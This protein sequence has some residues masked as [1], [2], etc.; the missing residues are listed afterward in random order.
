MICTK[1]LSVKQNTQLY[2]IEVTTLQALGLLTSSPLFVAPNHAAFSMLLILPVRPVHYRF[3]CTLYKMLTFNE[4]LAANFLKLVKND[5]PP[6]STKACVAG[7]VNFS[8]NCFPL[9]R[10]PLTHSRHFR[11][12]PHISVTAVEIPDSFRFSKKVVTPH[13]T[14]LSGHLHRSAN[15]IQKPLTEF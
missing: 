14:F 5:S 2:T 9:I 6:E 15:I 10:F 1:K 8:N 13:H 7:N 11:E 4:H 12:F 3:L